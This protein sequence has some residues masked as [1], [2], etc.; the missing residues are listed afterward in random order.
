M[1]AVACMFACRSSECSVVCR[2]ARFS[3]SVLRAAALI[4]PLGSHPLGS[5]PQIGPPG[6]EILGSDPLCS[7]PLGSEPSPA[8]ILVIWSSA[9]LVLG[10]WPLWPLR[11]SSCSFVQPSAAPFLGRFDPRLLWL[12]FSAC[13]VLFLHA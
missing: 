8:P 3:R 7:V 5:A 2:S 10:T 9:A 12:Q 4:D 11:C 1:L 6:I 13:F